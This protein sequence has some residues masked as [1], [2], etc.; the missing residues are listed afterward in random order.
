[1]LDEAGDLVGAMDMFIGVTEVEIDAG[2]VSAGG[3]MP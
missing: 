2:F 1:L 3:S